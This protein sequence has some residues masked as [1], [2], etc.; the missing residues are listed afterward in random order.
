MN[1]RVGVLWAVNLD[2]PIYRGE[3]DTTSR[4]IR[5]EQYG[6]FLL[7]ELEVDGCTLVLI[8]LTMQFK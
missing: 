5:A 2:D 3:I 6:V 4:N 8:L 7:N 1:V